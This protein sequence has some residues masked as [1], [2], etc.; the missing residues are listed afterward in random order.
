MSKNNSSH[1]NHFNLVVAVV[2]FVVLVGILFA[3]SISKENNKM[4]FCTADAMQ[5]PDGDTYVGRVGP[6]CEF[7]KCPDAIL[8]G[9]TLLL[10]KNESW[11]PCPARESNCEKYTKLYNSGKIVITGSENSE[12]MITAENVLKVKEYIESSGIMTKKCSESAVT[13]LWITYKIHMEI[14]NKAKEF[15]GLGSCKDIAGTLNKFISPEE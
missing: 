9:D 5:C 12:I 4:V 6:N 15:D 3:V 2:V 10:E 7:A 13:D 14:E 8:S 11:G 1:S